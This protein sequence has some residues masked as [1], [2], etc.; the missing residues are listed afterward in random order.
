MG[1]PGGYVQRKNGRNEQKSRPSTPGSQLGPRG[2][3]RQ[4]PQRN[5]TSI[6]PPPGL[7]GPPIGPGLGQYGQSFSITYPAVLQWQT[8]IQPPMGAAGIIPQYGLSYNWPQQQYEGHGQVP[9]FSGHTAQPAYSMGY[10]HAGPGPAQ[11]ETKERS[12]TPANPQS[13]ALFSSSGSQPSRNFAR[14]DD[15]DKISNHRKISEI[16]RGFEDD[17]TYFP[18]GARERGR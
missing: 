3:F 9:N 6:S 16:A 14:Q 5:P 18:A 13:N 1:N 12:Q 2:S 17:D 10:S 15:N 8:P 11:M 7:G 4:Q